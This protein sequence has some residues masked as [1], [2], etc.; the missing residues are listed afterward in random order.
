VGAARC[1]VP[2]EG[3]TEEGK[4]HHWVYLSAQKL[5]AD[6]A[7][8]D[9]WDEAFNALLQHHYSVLAANDTNFSFIACSESFLCGEWF[10]TGPA[11]IHF[12][13]EKSGREDEGEVEEYRESREGF[14]LKER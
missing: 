8:L 14:E 12:T 9:D 4:R 13:S 6:D 7:F 11:L 3:E 1:V 2:A 10:V 5:H